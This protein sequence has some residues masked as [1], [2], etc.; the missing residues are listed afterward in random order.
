MTNQNDPLRLR[1]LLIAEAQKR[2][3]ALDLP[4][5]IA[6]PKS[7]DGQIRDIP[8]IKLKQW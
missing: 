6:D 7:L 2:I 3:L 5:M 1:N 8:L 4:A